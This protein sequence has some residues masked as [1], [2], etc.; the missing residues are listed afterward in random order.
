MG[1]LFVCLWDSEKF[2]Q[3]AF[4]LGALSGENIQ[5]WLGL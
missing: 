4:L 5:F 1:D 3:H 2:V